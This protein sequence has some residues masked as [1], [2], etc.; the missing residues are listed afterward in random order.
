MRD[1]CVLLCLKY[2]FLDLQIN[3]R[4]IKTLIEKKQAEKK[5]RNYTPPEKTIEQNSRSSTQ[6]T[7]YLRGKYKYFSNSGIYLQS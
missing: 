5:L 1:D 4:T 6:F 3:S 2:A 7:I